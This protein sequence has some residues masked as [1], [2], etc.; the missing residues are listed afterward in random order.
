M[1][2]FGLVVCLDMGIRR[3][4]YINSLLLLI[5]PGAWH[6]DV[7]VFRCSEALLVILIKEII[8]NI[9]VVFIIRSNRSADSAR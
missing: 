7:C 2:V 8:E 4:A 3:G 1:V 5:S 9:V 6:I